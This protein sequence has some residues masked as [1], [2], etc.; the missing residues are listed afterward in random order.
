MK[1][2]FALPF[3]NLEEEEIVENGKT[4]LLSKVLAPVMASQT[5]GVD[6]L[7][8]YD[9]SRSIFK[10]ETIDLD[11]TDLDIIKNFI[12][13]NKQL[14]VLGKGRLLEAL[15]IDQTPVIADPVTIAV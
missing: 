3:K 5:E 10:G 8:F 13:S 15:E 2:N 11:R 7:K 9:W 4:V 12:K 6:V 1:I 14:S